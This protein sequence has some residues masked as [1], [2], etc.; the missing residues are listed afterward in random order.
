M[1]EDNFEPVVLSNDAEDFDIDDILEETIDNDATL[2]RNRTQ[3]I[4]DL[5]KYGPFDDSTAD[6]TI[7]PALELN[8]MP[9]LIIA[10]TIMNG[11]ASDHI[12]SMNSFYSRGIHQIITKLFKVEYK[13]MLNERVNTDEDKE[14]EY[15]SFSVEFTDCELR[16][17][18]D[19]S[20]NDTSQHILLPNTARTNNKTYSADLYLTAKITASATLRNGKILYKTAEITKSDNWRV[21]SIPVMVK[22]DLCNLCNQSDAICKQ[23][24]EDPRDDGGYFILKGNEMIISNLENLVINKPHGYITNHEKEIA[25]ITF[26]SKPGDHYENSYYMVIRYLKDKQITIQIVTSKF[27]KLEIPFYIIFRAFGMTRDIDI[28]DH[29][30]YGTNNKDDVSIYMYSVLDHAMSIKNKDFEPILNETSGDA[31]LEFINKILHD[32]NKIKNTKDESAVKFL[33][34]KTYSILDVCIFPHIGHD[35]YS[36]IRK[37][38]FLGHIIHKLLRITMGVLESTDRDSFKN[39]RI[40]SSGVS[41]AKAF[42]TQF[43]FAVVQEIRKKLIKEFENTS[44][45]KVSLIDTIKTAVRSNELEKSL[46]QAIVTGEKT[47]VIKKHEITNR[48]S[49]QQL[50]RRNDLNIRSTLNNI[51]THGQTAAKATG[52]AQD[53]RAVHPSFRGFIGPVQSADTGAKVGMEKQKTLT[54]RISEASASYPLKD[55]I[56]NDPTFIADDEL[57]P[58]EINRRKLTKVFVNGDWIGLCE[59]AQQFAAR[60]REIRRRGYINPDT[61]IFWEILIREI[62]F[63]VDVGRLLRPI[64]IVYNNHDEYVKEYQSGNKSAQ[65]KQWIKLTKKDIRALQ[66]GTIT[67]TDLRDRQIIEYIAPEEQENLFIAENLNQL[68]AD[69]NNVTKQYT[70]MG[71]DQDLFGAVELSAPNNNHTPASRNTMFT[72]HKRQ[73]AGWFS[74]APMHR[75]DK[76]TFFQCYCEMPLVRAFTNSIT[77]PNSQNAIV[78]YLPY[79]GYGQEDSLLINKSSIDRGLFNGYYYYYERT[80]LDKD[81]KFGNPD[82]SRTIDMKRDANYDYLDEH[83]FIKKGTLVQRGYVLISKHIKL[84]EMKDNF[85][86]YAD[87]S[88]IYPLDEPAIV[89]NVIY[90]RNDEDTVVAKVKLRS[91]MPLQAG[92]KLCLTPDHDVLTTRGWKPIAEIT[93]NDKIAT[94]NDRHILEYQRPTELYTYEINEDV[95][96][97]SSM[98]V[99]LKVNRRHRMYVCRKDIPGNMN[100]HLEYTEDLYGKH[101]SYMKS[102]IN[103]QPDLPIDPDYIRAVGFFMFN[104]IEIIGDKYV[105]DNLETKN[106]WLNVTK[107]QNILKKILK[108]CY[109]DG[110]KVFPNFIYKLSQY[111]S[112]LVLDQIL[113]K[114][115]DNNYIHEDIEIL[116]EIQII[117]LHAGYSANICYSI[118][119][120]NKVSVTIQ[121][122]PAHNYPAVNNCEQWQHDRIVP[123]EGAIHCI[124]VP[125]SVFYVRRNGMPVWTGNSSH[126]GC[127]GICA[128][129]LNA[130]DMPYTESGL[131]PDII[132]NPHSVPTR[133]II[134]QLIETL[135]A[136]VAVK[137]GCMFDGSPFTPRDIDGMISELADKFGIKYGGHQRMFNGKTGNY[138]DTFIFIGPNSYQR[139]LKF[140]AYENYAMSSGPTCAMTRQ[141]LEGKNKAGGLKIGEMEKDVLVT[142]GAMRALF[143]KFYKDSDGIEIY[144]CRICGSRAVVNENLGLYKCKKCKDLADIVCVP[145]AWVANSLFHTLSALSVGVNFEVEPFGYSQSE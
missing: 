58:S 131:I 79:L 21:A 37:L 116:E 134:G 20:Y 100:Y 125:N 117:A 90:P 138:F 93:K 57:S 77:L 140:I 111:Q 4:V 34:E 30:V 48:I 113:E 133:M 78:A 102:A 96:E 35:K 74:L 128:I 31:V 144:I 38:R 108:D 132:L 119:S 114:S 25:R 91:Y 40:H 50:K 13:N 42:K 89:E 61:T 68:R 107:N 127:K 18:M 83:G 97:V 45:S 12:K 10:E 47:L 139:L 135:M 103:R 81:E 65:F 136:L 9:T 52:R 73:A 120:N 36:R 24:Q 43:N 60:Y 7:D 27:E 28:I 124:K 49:S 5:T 130:D 17:P 51:T 6:N 2:P 69:V 22:S 85:Y 64:V 62:Y 11:S 26:Q 88:I 23:L 80:E 67:M 122:E 82:Y 8:D 56:M 94:L 112:G 59:N 126:S 105:Y 14:I 55:F 109:E 76:H 19:V 16:R 142:H 101:V 1:A 46:V 84:K 71:I 72:N 99:S 3:K 106:K 15:I 32:M 121:K 118:M 54:C 33:N 70:H 63:W 44:W 75:I 145:S 123:Y 92:D 143:A 115:I 86:L 87:K 39:K 53:M 66:S 98:D 41:I 137:R 95:Y 104:E 110:V 29:I 141:P 129:Q